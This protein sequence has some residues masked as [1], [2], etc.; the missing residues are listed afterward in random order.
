VF[1]NFT[2]LDEITAFDIRLYSDPSDTSTYTDVTV[3][4]DNPTIGDGAD[5]I[6]VP[7]IDPG[8]YRLAMSTSSDPPVFSNFL[9]VFIVR[10]PQ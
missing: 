5:Y 4:G 6:Q 3:M 1:W 9:P 7:S 10:N 8:E 2:S